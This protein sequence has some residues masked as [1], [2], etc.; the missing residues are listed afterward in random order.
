MTDASGKG[1]FGYQIIQMGDDGQLHAIAYGGQ[2]LTSS[3]RNWTVGQLE[4]YG[5]ILGL[6]AYECFAIHKEVTI[7]TDTFFISISGFPLMREKD[8]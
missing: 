2:A 1:G 4:L 6:R 3:Q 8:V 7:I 5:L